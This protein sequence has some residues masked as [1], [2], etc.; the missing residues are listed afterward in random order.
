MSDEGSRTALVSWFDWRGPDLV[1]ELRVQPRSSRDEFVGVLNDRLVLRIVAPPVDGKANAHVARM[2]ARAFGVP[3][4]SI[5]LLGGVRG[6]NKRF[7]VKAPRKFP[8][9][10]PVRPAPGAQG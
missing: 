8:E 2:L 3:K 7:L 4:S 5:E 1:L 10:L 6:R 9:Q